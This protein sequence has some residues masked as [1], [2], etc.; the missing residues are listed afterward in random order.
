MMD[1]ARE[2]RWCCRHSSPLDLPGRWPPG[3]FCAI[4]SF[5]Q[6]FRAVDGPRLMLRL[7]SPFADT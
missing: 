2:A 7:A 6:G 1:L 3:I 4:E 5:D